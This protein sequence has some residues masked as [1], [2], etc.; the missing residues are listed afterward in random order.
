MIKN[1]VCKC[2]DGPLCSLPDVSD[3]SFAV[4]SVRS[5]ESHIMFDLE[6]QEGIN[7]DVEISVLEHES[8]AQVQFM[9][10]GWELDD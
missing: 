2:A 8:T 4:E 5:K 7:I 1:N 3:P 10:V 9:D 6:D